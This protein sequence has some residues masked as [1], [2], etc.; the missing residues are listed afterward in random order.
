MYTI[1]IN[2]Y[3]FVVKKVISYY[4][5]NRSDVF[6]S[7]LDMQKAFDKVNLGFLF[8][9]LISHDIPLHMI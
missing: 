7:A 6:P 8:N 2:I 9:K 5:N 1:Y 3:T 4:C